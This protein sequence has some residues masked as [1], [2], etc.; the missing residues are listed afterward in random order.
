MIRLFACVAGAAFL[1]LSLAACGKGDGDGDKED[2]NGNGADATGGDAT[3]ADGLPEPAT[4]PLS[5]T[6]NNT[7]W[8]FTAGSAKRG[9]FEGEEDTWF[10][11]ELYGAPL[12]DDFFTGEPAGVCDFMPQPEDGRYVMGH[13]PRQLGEYK[14]GPYGDDP[15]I[16]TATFV[17]DN[18]D[19]SPHNFGTDK[20]RFYFDEITDDKVVGRMILHAENKR[21]GVLN[22]IDG[23][24]TLTRCPD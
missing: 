8:T 21:E 6:I 14:L 11:I 13:V 5:G 15:T 23:Q 18:P 24:F 7:P 10:K 3:G 20:G 16:R 17:Y 2:G 12:G 1:V 19:G 9:R 22:H 4:T